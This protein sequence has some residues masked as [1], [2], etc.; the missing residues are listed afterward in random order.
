MPSQPT[1][2]PADILTLAAHPRQTTAVDVMVKSPNA[3]GA[4]LDCTEAGKREKLDRYSSVLGELERQGITYEPA[5]FSAFGRRHPDVTRML[6]EA[7]RRVARHRGCAFPKLLKR[8]WSRDLAVAVWRRAASMVH[9][10]LHT[11]ESE[12]AAA[13]DRA[14]QDEDDEDAWLLPVG[15]AAGGA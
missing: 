15:V 8:G 5:V 2:R 1:W 9:R 11:A 7:S 4:G 12:A 14:N 6:N 13:G 3:T 10:C